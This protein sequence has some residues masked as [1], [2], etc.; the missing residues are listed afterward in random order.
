MLIISGWFDV[1]P[2]HVDAFME[3]ARPMIV[4]SR[5]EDGCYAY[6]FSQDPLVANHVWIN[7]RWESQAHLEAHFAAPHMAEFQAAISGLNRTAHDVLK[8]EIDGEGGPVR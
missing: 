4:A 8:F 3:A 1:D 7:E 6:T 5:A 2:D